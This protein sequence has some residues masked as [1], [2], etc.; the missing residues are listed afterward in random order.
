VAK[1]YK[2]VTADVHFDRSDI[3]RI[4]ED[5][6]EALEVTGLAIVDRVRKNASKIFDS[7]GGQISQELWSGD[8]EKIGSNIVVQQGWDNNYG[9]VLEFGPDKLSWEITTKRFKALR[10]KWAKAGGDVVYTKKVRRNWDKKSLRPHYGPAIDDETENM[11]IRVSN[12]VKG[13]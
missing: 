8:A 2:G 10:F 1:D 9:T 13:E 6:S 3:K 5:V 11:L 12:A 4:E 7:G